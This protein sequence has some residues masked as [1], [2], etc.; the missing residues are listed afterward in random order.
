MLSYQELPSLPS[1][2]LTN[3][4]SKVQTSLTDQKSKHQA[5]HTF[6]FKS[7]ESANMS[8][9]AASVNEQVSRME[10][11]NSSPPTVH[12][13]PDS[14]KWETP[15]AHIKAQKQ[16][17][18]RAAKAAKEA[19]RAARAEEEAK[20]AAKAKATARPVSDARPRIPDDEVCRQ[21]SIHAPHRV[22]MYSYDSPE[23]PKKIVII[24]GKILKGTA[25]T[26]DLMVQNTFACN[27]SAATASAPKRSRGRRLQNRNCKHSNCPVRAPH[28]RGRMHVDS[29]NV[30]TKIHIIM[31]KMANNC[32]SREDFQLLRDFNAVHNPKVKEVDA[33]E[34]D[35]E[36]V[37]IIC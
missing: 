20:R 8:S 31:G 1:D 12:S 16:R 18:E 27:H 17:I 4:N 9:T 2:I 23:L 15:K 6:N 24:Q 35:S 25:T 29:R 13:V 28:R 3:H 21:C 5:I 7:P 14:P 36:D 30:P 10:T 11:P 22:G 37:E 19:K 26:Q 34:M 33:V 32:A